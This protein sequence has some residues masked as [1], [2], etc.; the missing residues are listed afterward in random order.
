MSVRQYIHALVWTKR[1]LLHQ[2]SHHELSHIQ[3]FLAESDICFDIGAHGGSWT[4]PLAHAVPKGHVY[5]FEALPYYAQVL[6][7]TLKLL[8]CRN[9]TVVNKAVTDRNGTT[10]LVWKD[11][12][13]KRLT[14]RTHVA[15][16]NENSG[17]TVSV[18]TVT[19][20]S[21]CQSLGAPRI[22][23][24]KCDV[25]GTELSVLKGS[26]NLIE[27]WQPL[28]YCELW[29]EYCQRYGYAPEDVFQFFRQRG[30]KPY[31]ISP[32]AGLIPIDPKTYPGEADVLFAPNELGLLETESSRPNVA[33]RA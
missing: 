27:T 13:G 6:S 22:T 19:L 32:S 5:A 18:D 12:A 17:Q 31:T 14:G 15:T 24:V 29:H 11:S 26:V 28:F 1:H 9:V 10:R 8:G 23:F 7:M 20:D 33:G 25:E 4:R 21:F 16:V 2:Y 30:Y 3:P